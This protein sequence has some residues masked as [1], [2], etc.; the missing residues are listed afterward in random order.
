M[1][2]DS[3]QILPF[4]RN[5]TIFAGLPDENLRQISSK[6]R[7]ARF[8]ANDVIIRENTPGKDIMITLRGRVRVV[9]GLDKEPLD[10][11]EFGPGNCIGEVSVI[12][13]LNHS[14]SVI[15]VEETD[16][17]VVSKQLLMDIFKEDKELFSVL[18]LNI[19]RELARRLHFTDSILWEYGK[20]HERHGPVQDGYASRS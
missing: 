16:M 17:L 8:N 19:A 13:I 1:N 11:V 20:T 10:V 14:A 12:G 7:I 18:I 5:V 2:V 15:A 6:C 9:L 4:L 3:E